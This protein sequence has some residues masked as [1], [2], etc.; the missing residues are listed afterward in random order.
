MVLC[1]LLCFSPE[2]LTY[3]P[4]KGKACV[5]RAALCVL[6]SLQGNADVQSRRRASEVTYLEFSAGQEMERK[7]SE[8]PSDE[9]TA[10]SVS[11]VSVS[12]S[13]ATDRGRELLL[14]FKLSLKH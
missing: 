10:G 9:F 1:C 13:A 5:R 11:L 12:F 3:F 4:R 6:G 8:R 2:N 14:S 7:P